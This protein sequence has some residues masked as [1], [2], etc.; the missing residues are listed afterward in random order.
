MEHLEKDRAEQHADDRALAAPE[1]ATAEHRRRDAVQLVRLAVRRGG[2]RH[3]VEREEQGREAG[4]QARDDVGAGDHPLRVDARVAR[5]L[6]VAPDGVQVAAVHR[7][8]EHDPE[9]HGDDEHD[10]ELDRHAQ[11]RG[12]QEG[13]QTFEAGGGAVALG[14]VLR[15][16]L[17]EA[18]VDEQAA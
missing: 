17:R 13:A 10:P 8:V 12:L 14:L 7:A 9:E 15:D 11:R 6:L 2:D 5:G 18:A 3:G 4:H 16:V 1:R